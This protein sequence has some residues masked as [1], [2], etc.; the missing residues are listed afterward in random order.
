VTSYAAI[1]AG[2]LDVVSDTVRRLAGHEPI[3]LDEYVQAHP[4][5]LAHVG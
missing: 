2:E 3:T 5:S 1:G 4:A